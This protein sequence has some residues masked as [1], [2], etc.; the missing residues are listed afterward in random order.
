VPLEGL[1]RANAPDFSYSVNGRYEIPV[2]TMNLAI[3]ADYSWRDT[4]RGDGLSV[5]EDTMYHQ[6][7]AYG[8][9]GA[10][11]AL[12]DADERW[13]LALWGKNLTDEEYFVNVTTDD[14]ASWMEIP[15]EPLNYGVDIR[16]KW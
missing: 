12:H 15:G 2:G 9:L 8:L 6:L 3:M 14:V 10:R 11:V 16:Y 4:L 1:N 5:I 7:K 13:E